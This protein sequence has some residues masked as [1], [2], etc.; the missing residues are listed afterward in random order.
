MQA[1]KDK[2]VDPFGSAFKT[3]HHSLEILN[4]YEHNT[5]EEIDVFVAGL[6]RVLGMLR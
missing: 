5:K 6:K 3:T 4:K 1:L 2:G